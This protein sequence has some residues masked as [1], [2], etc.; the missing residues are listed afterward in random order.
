MKSIVYVHLHNDYTGS[1]RVLSKVI[2]KNEEKFHAIHIITNS[3]TGGFLSDI[4]ATYHLIKFDQHRNKYIRTLKL[5]WIQLIIFLKLLKIRKSRRQFDIYTNTLLPFGATLFGKL[6]KQKTIVHIHETSIRPKLLEKIILLLVNYSVTKAIYVSKT[7]YN[8]LPLHK[9]T[10]EIKYNSLSENF[11]QMATLYKQQGIVPKHILMISSLNKHKGIYTFIELAKKCPQYTFELVISA[12]PQSIN[13]EF[14]NLNI[15]KNLNIYSAQ[16]NIHPFYA[17]AAILLNLSNPDKWVESFGMTILEASFY[18]VP[19]IAPPIGGPTELIVNSHDGF[20]VHPKNQEK[21]I[22][23]VAKLMNDRSLYQSM[24]ENA[25]KKALT[26]IKPIFH[27]MENLYAVD[28]NK[29][30]TIIKP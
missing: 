12:A 6:F 10:L 9:P 7:C 19:S 28:K 4:D 27:N 1:T 25:Y 23:T 5:L 17:R 16:S 11:M 15:P 22:F 20:L 29:N 18:G 14:S 26:F 13:K 2:K 3:S 21:I 30:Q 8:S 24:S